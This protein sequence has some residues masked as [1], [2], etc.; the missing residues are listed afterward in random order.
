MMFLSSDVHGDA[1]KLGPIRLTVSKEEALRR[2]QEL[3]LEGRQIN[4]LYICT[5]EELQTANKR[6]LGWVASAAELLS[7]ITSGNTASD[8]FDAVAVNVLKDSEPIEAHSEQFHN[9]LNQRLE[10]LRAIRKGM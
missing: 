9:E 5:H 3:F 2:T 1:P 7:A 10:R 6:K 4:T 8:Y